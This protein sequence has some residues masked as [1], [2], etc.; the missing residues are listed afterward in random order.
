[1]DVF[2]NFAVLRVG[3]VEI[4]RVLLTTMLVGTH[5]PRQLTRRKRP[6]QIRRPMFPAEDNA[7]SQITSPGR[8][9]E[10]TSAFFN[11]SSHSNIPSSESQLVLGLGTNTRMTGAIPGLYNGLRNPPV[12]STCRADATLMR[13]LKPWA[14]TPAAAAAAS[15]WIRRRRIS[16]VYARAEAASKETDVPLAS[17]ATAAQSCSGAAAP[18]RYA[19]RS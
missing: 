13:E 19:S 15:A 17:A 7:Q 18:R 12:G 6:S 1:V 3:V 4:L 2:G 11:S 9:N 8:K 5:R 16:R 10:T 14:L